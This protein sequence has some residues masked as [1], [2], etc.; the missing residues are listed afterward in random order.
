MASAQE[1]GPPFKP[2]EFIEPLHLLPEERAY[3]LMSRKVAQADM[4][5]DTYNCDWLRRLQNQE[6]VEGIA[7]DAV[8]HNVLGEEK[9]ITATLNEIKIAHTRIRNM[10]AQQRA[11]IH[12]RLTHL[13]NRARRLSPR[14]RQAQSLA[15]WCVTA[16]LEARRVWMEFEQTQ[17]RESAPMPSQSHTYSDTS[18][19][20]ITNM[21]GHLTN[22]SDGIPLTGTRPK[23]T[24]Q[25]QTVPAGA[26]FQQQSSPEVHFAANE[27]LSSTQTGGPQPFE[28]PSSQP[29]PPQITT[30]PVVA[31]SRFHQPQVGTIHGQYQRPASQRPVMPALSQPGGEWWMAAPNAVR[32]EMRPPTHNIAWQSR[33]EPAVQA[34][35]PPASGAAARAQVAQAMATQSSVESMGEL[36]RQLQAHTDESLNRF[37]RRMMQVMREEV[38]QQ[39]S[40]QGNRDADANSQQSRTSTQP[41][42]AAPANLPTPTVESSTDSDHRS[43]GRSDGNSSGGRPR[44]PRRSQYAV[45]KPLTPNLWGFTFSGDPLSTDRKDVGAPAFI[46][47][48][49][50][51]RRSE[52]YSPE[53]M[54]DSVITLL[55]GDAKSWWMSKATAIRTYPQF[56]EEFRDEWFEP[57]ADT[58]T[59]L[60]LVAYKQKSEPVHRYLINFEAKASYCVPVPTDKQMVDILKRNLAEDYRKDVDLKDPR[61]VADVKNICKRIDRNIQSQR[62]ARRIVHRII[63]LRQTDREIAM[64]SW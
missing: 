13:Y 28:P 18:H 55:R 37:E 30:T 45:R 1:M 11:V 58:T 64:S 4:R 25:A 34:V 26:I 19:M 62:Q 16:V 61:T 5:D 38:S 8:N 29:L 36:L 32:S 24:P 53:D 50:M 51:Y 40:N 63:A 35:H 52:K 39:P 15:Q 21:G 42:R 27:W 31:P 46:R 54:L 48:V 57:D 43:D 59:Y 7:S 6:T 49:E 2:L 20:N 44:E 14:S 41:R 47:G 60:D 10:T 17:R 33:P 22:G 9:T 23:Q 3:E 56:I 12:S